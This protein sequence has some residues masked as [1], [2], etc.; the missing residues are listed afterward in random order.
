VNDNFVLNKQTNS[1]SEYAVLEALVNLHNKRTQEYI[2]MWGYETWEKLY[3]YQN[4]DYDYFDR[5]DE[6]YEEY[7]EQ[8][9]EDEMY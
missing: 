6:E 8:L 2:D 9:E 1:K 3:R 4:Y 5:L 7:E